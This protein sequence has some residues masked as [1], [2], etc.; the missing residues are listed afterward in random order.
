MLVINKHLTN[1]WPGNEF[2][3]LFNQLTHAAVPAPFLQT[4]RNFSDSSFP[5]SHL[6]TPTQA[7]WRRCVPTRNI[8]NIHIFLLCRHKQHVTQSAVKACLHQRLLQSTCGSYLCCLCCCDDANQEV[9]KLH[10]F[11]LC[12]PLPTKARWALEAHEQVFLTV[13]WTSQQRDPL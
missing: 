11:T 5:Q 3:I 13:T 12:F 10:D 2:V 7:L 6:D 9:L 8:T 1:I 4:L